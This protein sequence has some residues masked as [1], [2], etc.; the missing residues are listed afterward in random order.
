MQQNIRHNKKFVK[1]VLILLF[2]LPFYC[3]AQTADSFIQSGNQKANKKDYK[4]AI[5]DFT[6]AIE[7][8]PNLSKAY[9]YRANA[10]GNIKDDE[11]A[12]KDYTKTF[13]LAT[14]NTNALFYR[15]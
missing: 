4:G 6:R 14:A 3:F 9:F 8:N 5:A 2:M 7:I 15:A 10:Y 12:I 13:E 11:S 1:A